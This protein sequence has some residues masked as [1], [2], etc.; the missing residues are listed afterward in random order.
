MDATI[1]V[2]SLINN[3]FAIAQVFS[4]Q[5]FTLVRINHSVIQRTRA[6]GTP[7]Q[8]FMSDYPPILASERSQIFL[9]P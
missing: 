6:I 8:V 4:S 5:R 9:H 1:S 2:N 3:I 7:G